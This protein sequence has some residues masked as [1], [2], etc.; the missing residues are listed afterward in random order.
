MIFFPDTY[1]IVQLV[2]LEVLVFVDGRVSSGFSSF[3]LFSEVESGPMASFSCE[4]SSVSYQT[5]DNYPEIVKT[6]K[7]SLNKYGQGQRGHLFPIRLD[8]TTDKSSL[9]KGFHRE[10][11]ITVYTQK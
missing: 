11:S 8:I 7:F 3:C 4:V 10:L 6:Q 2:H 9:S 1:Q 5:Y